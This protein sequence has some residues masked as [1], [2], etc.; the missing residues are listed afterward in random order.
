MASTA[1]NSTRIDKI[2]TALRGLDDEQVAEVMAG[3]LRKH[4]ESL[5]PIQSLKFA[6][7]VRDAAKQ[8]TDE[9]SGALIASVDGEAGKYQGF[10]VVD[11]AGRSSI[12]TAVL[13]DQFPEAYEAAVSWGAPFKTVRLTGTRTEEAR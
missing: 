2:A 13:L 7:M 11:V 10:T 4:S 8:R 12:D 1:G 5:T 9:I 6:R 3:V